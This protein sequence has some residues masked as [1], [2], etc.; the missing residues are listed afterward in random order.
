MKTISF[1]ISIIH[2]PEAGWQKVG[3]KFTFFETVTSRPETLIQ[4]NAIESFQKY[5]FPI[6]FYFYFLLHGFQLYFKPLLKT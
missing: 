1:G 4:Q 3:C 5:V 2:R 6:Y